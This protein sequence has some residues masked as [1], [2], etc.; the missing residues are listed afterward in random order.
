VS[1]S[2][3]SSG[4]GCSMCPRPGPCACVVGVCMA[5]PKPKRWPGAGSTWA[6]GRSRS[7]HE[8]TGRARA[9]EGV[10]RL[11]SAVRSV[12][13]GWYARSSSPAPASPRPQSRGG[14]K[15]PEG[16]DDRGQPGTES[17]GPGVASRGAQGACDEPNHSQHS[18]IPVAWDSGRPRGLRPASHE[19]STP[20]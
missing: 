17:E 18:P 12:G 8:A 7:P 13:S 15:W 20:G 16:E 9:R 4:A 1:P 10:R 3:R 19:R 14:S 5:T 2:S 6:K 11:S